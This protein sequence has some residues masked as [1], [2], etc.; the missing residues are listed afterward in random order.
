V[1]LTKISLVGV[2]WACASAAVCTSYENASAADYSADQVTR[3]KYLV[4]IGICESCHT[5]VTTTGDPIPGR[6]LAGGR[7]TGP[8]LSA[9]L[10]PD[11]ET[12]LG[13]W[14]DDQI[15]NAIRNGKRPDGSDIRP[16]MGVFFYRELSDSDARS[17][18]AYLRSVPPVRNKVEKK[19]PNTPA[20]K[21]TIVTHVPEP[22][23]TDPLVNGLYMAKTVSHCMQCHTPKGKEGLPDLSRMGAGGNSYNAPGGGS[24]VS[25]NLTPSNN[26][27]ISAWTDD[28]VKTVITYGVR[29]DGSQ[30]VP[31]MD[32]EMYAQ[33]A[34]KDLSD[35]V[36]FLRTLKPV[37]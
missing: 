36:T 33:M 31:V 37:D 16:P 24:V 18:V 4:T 27:G 14:T 29:P 22:D 19:V 23:K 15:V 17:I 30:V 10:T 5:S 2:I 6:S 12:G 9:N 28:Q 7:P 1:K 34:P 8:L 11:P 32:F 35:L 3:G 20:P 25:A 13:T 26:F 21:F